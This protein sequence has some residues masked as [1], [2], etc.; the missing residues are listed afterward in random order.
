LESDRTFGGATGR[1]LSV[2]E[3]DRVFDDPNG[4]SLSDLERD[5]VFD[6]PNGRS[7]SVWA[8]ARGGTVSTPVSWS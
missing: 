4:Q 8:A 6:D 7:L 1:S 3:R 2:L 5:R